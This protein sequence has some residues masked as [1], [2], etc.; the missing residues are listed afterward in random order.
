VEPVVTYPFDA[1]TYVVLDL[2]EP[3]ASQV[4][5]IRQKN[6]DEFRM[7]LPAEVTLAGSG[8]VGCFVEDEEPER[9][10]SILAG[11]AATTSPIRTSL[12]D[13]MRFPNTDIFA[14]RFTEEVDLR[15][16]HERITTS[17]IRF[18]RSPFPYTPHCTLR[19]RSP[20]TEAEAAALLAE[21]I[22]EP[23]KLE[24]MSVYRLDLRPRPNVPVIC[25]L[26]KRWALGA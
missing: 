22:P 17:G 13:V 11:I 1:D 15:A 14:F 23:F 4:M 16:L 2:P 12:A 8:G 7:A 10:W 25:S 9:V 6:K 24:Q 21:R 3:V 26:M 5:A 19:G 20:V 18:K